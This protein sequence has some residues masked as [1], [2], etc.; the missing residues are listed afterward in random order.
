M[1][2]IN[3]RLTPEQQKEFAARGIINPLTG[4]ILKPL[5]WT[6]N[7]D[8][9]ACLIWCY[10]HREAP[11]YYQEFLFFYGNTQTQIQAQYIDSPKE[12]LWEIMNLAISNDL[13][14]EKDHI[15]CL[16]Q[17]AFE[18]YKGDGSPIVGNLEIKAK[19]IVRNIEGMI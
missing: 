6:I 17:E 19:C 8:E 14:Q 15:S 16:V 5:Y 1:A 3:E 12:V 2:F 10:S 13:M 7:R 18:S 11:G 9:D 4:T